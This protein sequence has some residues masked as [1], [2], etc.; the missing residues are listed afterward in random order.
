MNT[1]AIGTS[2]RGSY[3]AITIPAKCAQNKSHQYLY[4]EVMDIVK[5]EHIPALFNNEGIKL[6]NTTKNVIEKLKSLG[7]KYIK[8]EQ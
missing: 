3:S 4:N 6:S 8:S 5:K 7:I 2:F 1:R